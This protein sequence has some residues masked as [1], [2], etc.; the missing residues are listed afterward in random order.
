MMKRY[1][2]AIQSHD[3]SLALAVEDRDKAVRW[4]TKSPSM[5]DWGAALVHMFMRPD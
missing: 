2:D 5:G 4:V 1:Q 3:K